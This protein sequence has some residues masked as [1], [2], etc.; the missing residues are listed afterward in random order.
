MIWESQLGES[1]AFEVCLWSAE[2]QA[3]EDTTWLILKLH[4]T[5]MFNLKNTASWPKKKSYSRCLVSGGIL[6]NASK[7]TENWSR[8]LKHEHYSFIFLGAALFTLINSSLT[9][10]DKIFFKT[11]KNEQKPFFRL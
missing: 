4:F 6:S 2:S 9:S 1:P 11:S 8:A 10:D 5:E 7:P 3:E